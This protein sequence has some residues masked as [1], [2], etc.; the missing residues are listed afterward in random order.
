MMNKIAIIQ[1]HMGSSRLP[2]KVLQDLAGKPM[3]A[4][5]L[6]RVQRCPALD[7]LVV[8]TSTLAVDDVLAD[9]C[10]EL[11]VPVFRGSDT[12]VLDRFTRAAAAFS[13]DVC[14]RITSD[15]PLI[16][17]EVS[18]DIIRR[19]LEAQG[20]IDY[21]SNK[22]PQSFPRGLD[23]EVF[24]LAALRAAH[25]E[26]KLPYQRAHVTIYLY[27]HPEKFRLL[28]IKSLV[29]RAHWRW[30]VD[31]PEDLEFVRQVYRRLGADGNF[32]WQEVVA[33]LEQEPG[34]MDLNR[35]IHQKP[36]RQG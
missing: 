19:F 18:E 34:L 8:A 5:V 29:D 36:V 7:G 21:A 27:E 23:T 13:A 2:G 4:R 16:D 28:S 9:F 1:A 25:Q 35:H 31:T 33:L 30:T 24:T 6:E 22:I 12:D 26:A 17:P 32:G 10:R 15:C 14:V 11:Q 20:T 3:L